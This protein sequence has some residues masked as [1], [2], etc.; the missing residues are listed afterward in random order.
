MSIF[1][2]THPLHGAVLKT[3]RAQD[4]L[5]TIRLK[6]EP[7]AYGDC[8]VT[9]EHKR[10][11][12]TGLSSLRFTM[13]Q[14]SADLSVVV[15]DFLFCLRS[16]LDHIVWALVLANPPAKPSRSNMFPVCSTAEKFAD[17]VSRGRLAGLSDAAQTAVEG[18]QPYNA[19]HNLLGLL[20][21]L[22]NIDKHSSL[23]LTSVS[24]ENV[25]VT[26]REGGEDVLDCRFCG[27]DLTSQAELI[28]DAVAFGLS[29]GDAQVSGKATAAV[30][31]QDEPCEDYPIVPLFD[32]I[33]DHFKDAVFPTFEPFFP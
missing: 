7:F 12:D 18:L 4:H 27:E 10:D 3:V 5:D 29:G 19:R 30:V 22:H 32:E 24:I 11:P 25:D 20:R 6:V 15:G 16:A 9:I 1:T 8:E 33:L 21:D 23:H 28:V 13:P 26:W 14:P 17:Q 31:F 2:A